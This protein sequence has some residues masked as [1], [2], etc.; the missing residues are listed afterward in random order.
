M[1]KKRNWRAILTW[2]LFVFSVLYV[3]P[4][5][6]QV[7]SWYPFQKKLGGGLDLEGGLELRYTVDW[8]K[9][10]EDGGRKVGDSVRSR[11]VE[12]LAKQDNKNASDLPKSEWDAYAA[13]VKFEPTDIN[14]VRLSFA[15]EQA[16]SFFDSEMLSF[17]DERY[18]VSSAGDR[19]YD[20][21][22]PDKEVVKVQAQ[23]VRESRDQ[24]EKRVE[25]MGLID[26]DVRVAGDSD[27]SVQ[28]PGIGKDQMDLVRQHLGRT[29]QL[30]M[31]FVDLS[32]DFFKQ[33]QDALEAFKAQRG[34]SAASLQI[35]NA[36]SSTGW[37]ARAATKS[38]LVRFVR[39]LEVPDSHMIGYEWIERPDNEGAIVDK[40]WRTQFLFDKVDVAGTHLARARSSYDEKNR[41]VVLLDFNSEGARLFAE[42]TGNNVKEYM[43]ILLDDDVK[44]A[45]QIEEKIAGG[46]ARITMGGG[47]NV[48]QMVK[49]ARALAQVLNQGAY[50]A[51]VYKVHDNEVGPSL[52]HDSVN[53]GATAL[54]LGLAL[55]IAF[56]IL[57]YRVSGAI[58]VVVLLFNMLLIATLLVSFN[59]RLTLPGI[60]GIILT[61]GMAVD[62]NIIIFERIREELAAGRTPRAAVDTGYAKAL[63]AILDANITTA[64]AGFILLNY[65]SGTIRNFAVTL[66][67]GIVASVFTAV[68]VARMIFNYW[69]NSKK[70]SELSI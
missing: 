4:S 23:I 42:A 3:L 55:V 13:R 49:E 16:A 30:T 34:E 50:Q 64:L 69:L 51:P 43:A 10:V 45:P 67:M 25:G 47:G 9:A 58:A 44:S 7:P 11:V 31:R 1:N 19:A 39:T 35:S 57:Y 28:I 8:K 20:L 32:Q 41:P 70:P 54:I 63:S 21:I 37:Y 68:I 17:I 61:I 38:E 53:A 27:I 5:V 12:E 56:M 24:I 36:G 62:A 2:A 59:S 46:R 29:A 18:E 14:V 15:D 60:A 48:S 40:Y 65:T 52:G 26:P 33:Q 22:L 6:V 66:L